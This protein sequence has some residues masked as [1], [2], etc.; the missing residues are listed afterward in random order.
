MGPVTILDIVIILFL[1]AVIVIS[2]MRGFAETACDVVGTLLATL[3]AVLCAGILPGPLTGVLNPVV[4]ESLMEQ[5]NAYVPVTMPELAQAFTDEAA[6]QLLR[7][8]ETSVLRPLIFVIALLAVGWVWLYLCCHFPLLDRFPTMKRFN[9]LSGGALGILKA[10]VLLFAI[11]F[12]LTLLGILPITA[13]KGSF[14]LGWLMK[15]LGV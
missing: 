3:A 8:M 7:T 13:L 10:V 2:A 6:R 4:S 11:I 15:L 1:L 12:P 14:L 9:Q 5:I